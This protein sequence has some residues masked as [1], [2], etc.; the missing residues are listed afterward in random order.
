MD[1]TIEVTIMR[2]LTLNVPP[3]IKLETSTVNF[4]NTN[5]IFV[6]DQQERFDST[7][8][9]RLK[10]YYKTHPLKLDTVKLPFLPMDRQLPVYF[11]K[12]SR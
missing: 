9:K 7:E 3:A 10:E 5:F 4:P 11:F 8:Y 1:K 2:P 12:V 6:I